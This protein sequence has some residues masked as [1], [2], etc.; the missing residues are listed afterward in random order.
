MPYIITVNRPGCLSEQ[1]PRAV[2]TLDEAQAIAHDDLSK[3]PL[4]DD[5]NSGDEGAYREFAAEIVA[6]DA[7]GGRIG[8]MPG[9]YFIYVQHIGLA[10]LWQL[11]RP[12]PPLDSPLPSA[13]EIIDAYNNA[14]NED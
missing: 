10:E 13:D 12:D 4:W 6:L 2:A 3:S 5:A 8:P 7:A 9:D 1:D 11:V 14:Y